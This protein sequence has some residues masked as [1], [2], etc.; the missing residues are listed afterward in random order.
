MSAPS[1]PEAATGM[2]LFPEFSQLYSLVAAE[3]EPLTD[4]QLD[5]CAPQWPW[6]EWSIRRQLSHMAFAIYYWLLVIWGQTLFPDGEHGVADVPGL[7]DSGYDR[8]LDVQRYWEKPVLLDKFREAVA[9]VQRVLTERSVG[10]LRSHTYR[11]DFPP[12]WRLMIQA[13]PTGVTP[14]ADPGQL[15]MTLEATFRHLYF[16]EITHLYNIHRLKRA[17][18]LP[19]VVDVP[20]VGYWVLD[21]WDQSEAM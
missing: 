19:T 18:G 8:H 4:V 14:T 3:I 20:R 16:E 12:H 1:I 5:F 11:R 7:T 10:F 6:A 15:A 21:G 9:L 2:R 17:Q 13:H